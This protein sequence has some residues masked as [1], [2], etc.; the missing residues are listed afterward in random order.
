MKKR[1]PHPIVFHFLLLTVAFSIAGTAFGAAPSPRPPNIVFILADDLGITPVGAYGNTYY[2]TPNID[3]LARE[4]MRFT[5]A[6]SACP[7]CSPT[8]GALMTGKYPARTHLTDFIAGNPFPFARLKQPDWQ[9]FLPLSEVTVAEELARRGYVTA[10]FGKWHLARGYFPPQSIEE[11][12]DRQGF[13]EHFITHKPQGKDDPEK[14]A[15]GV[16][17]ITMRAFDFMTRH[18]DRPFFLYLTHNSIHAPLMAPKALVEKYRKRPGADRPDSNP[19]IAAMMEVLDDGIGRVVGKLDELGLS[20]R[21]LVIFH[22][23][24]GGRLRDGVQTPFRGGKAQLYEGGI[25]VPLVMRWPGVIAAG[26]QSDM[27][28]TSVDF[29]PTLLELTG[30][31]AA[32]SAVLDGVSLVS[33]LRGGAAPLREAIYWHYPHYHASGIHGPAGAIRAGD[34]KLIEYYETSL[35]GQGTSFELFNLKEDP[36]EERNLAEQEP[37]RV[38]E[39]RKLLADWLVATKA[40]MPTVNEEYDPSKAGMRTAD[41][42]GE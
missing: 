12:P 13:V 32:S 4:G 39:L 11:G 14:D 3:R 27:P 6:Y 15:H 37:K 29:F 38:V 20:E 30:E 33:H 36:A 40:Q 5:D 1:S 10:L 35:T 24:N 26:R 41:S 34:W 18:R 25:R 9:K 8:R 16:E 19:V 7:V 31:P 28:V 23:D 21:T 17:A 42:G 2:Q 22:S